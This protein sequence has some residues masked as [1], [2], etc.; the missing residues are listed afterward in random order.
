MF[1]NCILQLKGIQ[2]LVE[3]KTGNNEPRYNGQCAS[4]VLFIIL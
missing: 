1:Y 4:G 3:K 2:N